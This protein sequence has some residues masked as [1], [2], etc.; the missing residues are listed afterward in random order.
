MTGITAKK[1]LMGRMFR[2]FLSLLTAFFVSVSGVGLIVGAV[3]LFNGAMFEKAFGSFINGKSEIYKNIFCSLFAVLGAFL[4]ALGKN[5]GA[6]RVCKTISGDKFVLS[7]KKTV[8]FLLCF[9]IRVL[10][11]LCWGFLYILPCAVCTSFLLMSLSQGAMERNVLYSWITGSV[12]LLFLGLF[13]LFVTVQ[14]YSL[15]EYYL[16]RED[17]GVIS[18]LYKSLEKTEGRCVKIALFRISML[19]WILSCVLIVPAVFVLPY[20]RVSVMLFSLDISEKEQEKKREEIP[21]AVFKVIK[22]L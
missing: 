10:F 1:L 7:F 4:F 22:D 2:V 3:Y 20:Y 18:S 13:F 14:R 6:K 12:V 5:I 15:W 19:G 9:C 8:Q 17:G 16:C 21:P 11:T